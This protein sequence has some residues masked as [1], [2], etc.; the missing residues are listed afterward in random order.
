MGDCLIESRASHPLCCVIDQ[1]DPIQMPVDSAEKRKGRLE[2]RFCD[3]E[4]PRR[5]SATA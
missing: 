1:L 5:R 4:R 3:D 2:N